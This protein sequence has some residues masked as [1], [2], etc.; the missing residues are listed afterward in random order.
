ML[1][2]SLV[3][4]CCFVC[5][6]AFGEMKTWDGKHAI[7]RIDVTVVYFVPKDRTPLS[8]WQQRVDYFRRRLELFHRREF[9]G[10]STLTT[11]RQDEPLVSELTSAE[12]REGDANAIF[13]RTLRETDRRLKFAQGERDAFPI[14]LVLSEINWR[15]LDDFYRLHPKDGRLVFEGNYSRNEHFPGATSGGARATYLAR[16]GVGWG[17]VS[18]DGWRVPYRGTDCVV[19]HEGCGHTVG[20]PHPEPGNKSVMS[21]GQYHGWISESWLDKDQKVRLGWEPNPQPDDPQL[22]L[23]SRFRALPAPRVPKPDEPVRLQLDWPAETKVTSL[24]VRIQ[25]AV[26]GP[27][28]DVAQSWEGDTPQ[29]ATVGTF[30]RP[31]PVSYRVDATVQGG[32][33]IELWGYFQVRS[34]PRTNPQPSV[35]SVDLILPA[36]E[37]PVSSE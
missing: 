12:L 11:S 8:D 2:L 22:E 10:Q 16:R 18:A 4:M 29:T 17:L 24:R 25:T 13:F 33:S 19:Y 31:T 37:E 36:P 26:R 23:F 5:G 34:D 9:E 7:D 28:V 32:A 30:D 14:L 6:T 15:L 35:R 1:R 27:W 20:L 3:V 21:L